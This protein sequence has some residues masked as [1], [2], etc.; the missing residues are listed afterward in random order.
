MPFLIRLPYFLCHCF[1]RNNIDPGPH[2]IFNN[3]V[4]YTDW[5]FRFYIL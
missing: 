1:C 2:D 3:H 4:S 5:R